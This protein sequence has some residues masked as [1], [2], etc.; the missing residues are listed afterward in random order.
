MKCTVL[1]SGLKSFTYLYLQD[2]Y[3]FEE[4]P[5]A[6]RKVFGKPTFVM[7]LELS[8]ERKLALEDVNQVMQNLSENGYH[9]QMPPRDDASG[10]LDL[11]EKRDPSLIQF[12]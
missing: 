12:D 5:A 3:A 1:R 9:L 2:G 8:S 6:L 7:N 10:L 4:L 11:P